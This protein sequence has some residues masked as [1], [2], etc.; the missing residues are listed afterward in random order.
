[1]FSG[2]IHVV[3]AVRTPL[4]FMAVSYSM[5]WVGMWMVLLQT[6]VYKFLHSSVCSL[7]S[8]VSLGVDLL[9][10]TVLVLVVYSLS[11]V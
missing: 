11:R 10:H 8:G 4:L 6:F 9:G 1:M 7:L 2:T 3:A 5:V